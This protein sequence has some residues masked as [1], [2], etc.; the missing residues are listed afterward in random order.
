[1][2]VTLKNKQQQKQMESVDAVQNV[3]LSINCQ[4]IYI[5]TRIGYDWGGN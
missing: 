2:A 1:M 3:I 4:D 5:E